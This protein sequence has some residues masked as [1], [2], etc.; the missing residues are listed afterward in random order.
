MKQPIL[1]CYNLEG[2]RLNRIRLAAMRLKIRIRP[3]KKEEYGKALGALCGLF[4]LE[5]EAGAPGGFDDEML[6]MANFPAGMM[7]L[8]LQTM[9]RTGVAPVALKAV[10]MPTNAAWDSVRL[11]EEIAA[12][13]AALSGGTGPVHGRG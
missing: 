10:L 8:L 5:E 9:R 4:P 13:H 11:H 7:N 3:V 12:E 6:V 2:E 1:L